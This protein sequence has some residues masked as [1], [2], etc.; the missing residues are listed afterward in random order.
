M[1]LKGTHDMSAV[2]STV[3]MSQHDKIN[4]HGKVNIHYTNID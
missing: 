3:P 1:N 2:G 4:M